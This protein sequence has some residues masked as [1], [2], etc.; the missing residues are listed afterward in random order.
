MVPEQEHV[1]VCVIRC[2]CSQ[3]VVWGLAPFLDLDLAVAARLPPNKEKVFPTTTIYLLWG[4]R[5]NFLSFWSKRRQ[6]AASESQRRDKKFPATTYIV[7][8]FDS[9]GCA[10][11]ETHDFFFERPSHL[12]GTKGQKRLKA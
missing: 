7:E 6:A 11:D 10:E 3:R 1:C 5:A 4:W 9:N 8:S 12:L 2:S